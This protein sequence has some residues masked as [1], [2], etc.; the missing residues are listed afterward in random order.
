MIYSFDDYELNLQCY[1]LR[2]SRRPVK[3]EP[4]VFNLL[5]YLVQ[6]RDCLISKEELLEQLCP[7]RFVSEAA[8]TCRMMAM[9]RKDCWLTSAARTHCRS[10]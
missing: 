4:Q 8:L 2:S 7:G 3:L 10:V 9:R 6:H 5:T 1:E